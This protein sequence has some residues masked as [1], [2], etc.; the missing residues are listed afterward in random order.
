MT[1]YWTGERVRLRAVEPG[2][3]GLFARLSAE[4]ERLGDALNPPQSAEGW[5][6]FARE[7]AAADPSGDAYQLV[8][9]SVADGTAVGAIGVHR[10]DP[11]SGWFEYG[12]TV[13]EEHRRK[14]Y[15]GEAVRMVLRHQFEER[16]CHKAT[17]RVFAHN[18]P[19]LALQ[20]AVGFAEEGRLGR[21]VFVR[22]R[23]VDVVLFALFAEEFYAKYGE[24]AGF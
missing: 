10:A 21:H 18:G 6:A 23:H 17:A 13:A 24:P 12:I 9:E 4:E 22:G 5:E 3:G 15:A 16:R 14:G 7:K 19:S 20:Q 1:S 2:D 11:R 8:I